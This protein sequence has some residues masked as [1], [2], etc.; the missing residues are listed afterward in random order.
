[1]L[2]VTPLVVV[3]PLLNLIVLSDSSEAS[4]NFVPF[5]NQKWRQLEN[6]WSWMVASISFIVTDGLERCLISFTTVQGELN[7]Y[8][9]NTEVSSWFKMDIMKLEIW[10]CT[11][12]LACDLFLY[13]GYSK[14]D[15]RWIG[16][17][18]IGLLAGPEQFLPRL[19]QALKE[20][21]EALSIND[22]PPWCDLMWNGT[23]TL[24]IIFE[25]VMGEKCI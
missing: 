3:Y 10:D 4:E 25:K 16:P 2:N 14:V 21:G 18:S 6:R 22:Q 17:W 1:M 11:I 19:C 20:S 15:L 13:F 7:D 5:Q 24:G 23:K 12:L 9:S 8:Y